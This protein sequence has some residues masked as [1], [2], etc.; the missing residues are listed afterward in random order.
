MLEGSRAF[1]VSYVYA[2]LLGNEAGRVIY[3]GGA[4]IASGGKLLAAGPR[5]SFADRPVTTAVVDVDAT[6][7]HAGAHRQLHARAVEPTDDRLRRACRS[8]CRGGRAA[9]SPSRASPPWEL[10]RTSKEEEFARAVALGLFDYLRKSR[11][12]GLRRLALRRRRFERGRRAS[13]R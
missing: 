3:D 9:S 4:L 13:S 11:S 2:N 10:V 5:F 12:H 7:M 1:G 6:R 8:R